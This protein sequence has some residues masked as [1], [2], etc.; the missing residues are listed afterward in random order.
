MTWKIT[1]FFFFFKL[2]IFPVLF[3]WSPKT[4]ICNTNISGNSESSLV[5]KFE[6]KDL[7]VVN[8]HPGYFFIMGRKILI[9]PNE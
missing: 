1:G 6:I 9:Y 8:S 7:W 3:V 5:Q 2:R 4:V